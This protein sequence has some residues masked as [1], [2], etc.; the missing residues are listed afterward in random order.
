ML[1]S[2]VPCVN[3]PPP[4]AEPAVIPKSGIAAKLDTEL[5]I[6]IDNGLLIAGV[7]AVVIAVCVEVGSAIM[8]SLSNIL[9]AI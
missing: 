7:L 4:G 6:F 3:P 5:G 1:G 2:A 8:L 9:K